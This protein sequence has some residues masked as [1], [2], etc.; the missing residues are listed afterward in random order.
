MLIMLNGP[1]RSGKDTA[2]KII[3]KYLDSVKHYKLSR[4]LKNGVLEIFGINHSDRLYLEEFKDEPAAMLLGDTY[5]KTQIDLYLHLE[6]VYGGK[7][8][9]QLAILNL[10]ANRTTKHVVISDAG[11]TE[12]A[13]MMIAQY[14]N[15]CRLIQLKRPGCTFDNDIREYVDVKCEKQ[16]W[17]DNKYDLELFDAQ[18]RKVLIKWELIDED[19]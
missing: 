17:I 5:R 9:A 1:P 15:T 14:G 3:M 18:I 12:E 2:A 4:P 6:K 11:K 10:N 7:I 16:V 19:N 13:Q 8:L